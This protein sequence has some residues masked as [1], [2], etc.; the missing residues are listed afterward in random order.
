M[1][2]KVESFFRHLKERTAVFH[3]K[4]SARDHYK[5]NNKHQAILKPTHNIL[6]GSQREVSKN[7]YL[8]TIYPDT[9][10]KDMLSLNNMTRQNIFFGVSRKR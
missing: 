6:P 9:I 1:G 8:D 10:A 5:G 3:H 4:M 2:N 7:A